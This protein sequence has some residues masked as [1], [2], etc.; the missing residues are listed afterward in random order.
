MSNKVL[1]VY[2]LLSINEE[3]DAIIFTIVISII[4]VIATIYLV[5]CELRK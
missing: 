4:I 1:K 3:K 5:R 2:E